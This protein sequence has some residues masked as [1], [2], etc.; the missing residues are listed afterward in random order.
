MQGLDGFW[1]SLWTE[2]GFVIGW[3]WRSLDL[4]IPTIV[5]AVIYLVLAP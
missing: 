3:V 4:L 2:L 1:P 5:S